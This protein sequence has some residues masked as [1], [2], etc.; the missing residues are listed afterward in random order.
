MNFEISITTGPTQ[1]VMTLSTL[2][3]FHHTMTDC[4]SELYNVY[5]QYNVNI[6]VWIW[7]WSW[8][9]K[10]Q[11][12]RGHINVLIVCLQAHFVSWEPEGHYRYSAMFHWEPEGRYYCT[13][14]MG[15]STLLGLNRTLLNCDNALLILSRRFNLAP[16]DVSLLLLRSHVQKKDFWH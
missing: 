8:F 12:E 2:M 10:S 15:D 13:K 7:K 5:A 3:D 16:N 14:S 1:A 11:C 9:E 6:L 4:R